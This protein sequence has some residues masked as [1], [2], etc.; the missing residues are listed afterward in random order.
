M[1]FSDPRRFIAWL[2]ILLSGVVSASAAQQREFTLAEPFGLSWGPDRVNVPVEFP[3]GEVAAD[4]VALQDAAG[5]AVPVQLD[6]IELWP[7]GKSVKK[8]L[9]SFMVTLE[10]DQT[11]AW[12]LTADPRSILQEAGGEVRAEIRGGLIELSNAKTGVRL[13]GGKRSYPEPVAGE[14]FPAPIQG[15]RLP[16]G[17]WIGKGS[18]QTDLGCTGYSAR[19]THRGPVFVRAK[20]RYEFEGCKFYAA[21]VEL[22]AGQDLAV[23]SEEYNLSEGRRYPMTGV[24]GMRPDVQYAYVRPTF[25]S[26][27]KALMWDW[28]GQTMAKLPTP[29]AYCFSFHE[30][31]RPDS[32]DFKGN[33]QYGNLKPGDGGLTYNKDG[34]FAYLNAYLQWGDEETLYLGLWNAKEPAQQIAFV[35]LRPSQWLHPDIDPHPSNIL[36]QYVQTNCPTFERRT[37]GEAFLRAP[38]CLGK[39]VYGLGG[40]LRKLEKQVLPERGGPAVTPR[41]QWGSNLMLRYIRLG[42]VELDTVRNWQVRYDEPGK[43][44]RMYVPEGD[45]ARYESRRTRRPLAEAQAALAARKE[46][47]EADRKA[48][49]DAIQKLRGTVHHFA[50]VAYGHMDYGINLGLIANAAED[51]LASPACTPRQAEDIRRWM[52]A[53]VYQALNPNFVPPRTAGFAW[54]SANMMAQVQCRV[55]YLASLL[56]NHPMAKRWREELAHVVTLYAEDQINEAGATLECPHYGSMAIIM[57]AH[58]LAALGN[59]TG[60]DLSRAERRLR[61]A[62]RSRLSTMLPWDLR[63][64]LRSAGSEGDSYYMGDET[65]APLAGFFQTRDPQLARQ[66]AWGLKESG[67]MLGGHADASFK[68]VDPGLEP[69]AP[70]LGS[71]HFPGFG[72]VLRNG[73]P[74]RDEACV[75]VYAG[76]FSWGHG[77]NDRGAWLLYAKG[78]PLMADFAGMY[79]PSMREQWMHPGGLTFNHDETVRPAGDD[80]KDDWWRGSANAGYRQLKTAPFTVVEMKENPEARDDL[81]TFGRVT[82][83]RAA[84]QADYAVMQR[85]VG[86]LHRVAFTLKEPHGQDGFDDSPHAEVK[87]KQPFLWT[88]QFAFVKD[89]DPMG[90]NYLVIRDDLAGNSELDPS[91]NLWALADRIT[92]QGQ[93]AIY[94]GQHGVDLHCYVAEP[95]RF[96]P[97]TRVVGHSAGFAFAK[98]YR[99]TF[100]KPF[101]EDQIQLRIPQ[102]SR[103]GGFF[104]AIV[105][106]KQGEPTPQFATLAG[107][108][109][110]RVKF[111]DRTDTI[112]MRKQPDDLDIDGLRVRG[113]AVLVTQ[114]GGKRVV[115]DLSL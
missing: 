102:A 61:A 40:V 28:W 9:A 74:R 16:N 73:F 79:T 43:Y 78:V 20:L 114:Q 8:A 4:G 36:K 45:R 63:G 2:L 65:F 83:F 100:G 91:L 25:A 106:V 77:H 12:R 112:V 82:A 95:A 101:R 27:D 108:R 89:A 71:A 51:A 96:T 13:A 37:S 32:A 55:C 64:D 50:Q 62:A 5:Q 80:P 93:V 69:L 103:G 19:I 47:A 98:H 57:P 35:A 88:R 21:T 14:Q 15:V 10:P 44:P 72:F 111:P 90:H 84:P 99:E 22:N 29:N 6:R 68:M 86:Y 17:M 54:G 81:G 46:P 33:S 34:R 66:L 75:L 7:D 107:G 26:P 92:V 38:V 109:A 23:V 18:W 53:I 85:Q 87:L 39:R 48:V 1:T 11:A 113:T 110:I 70:T 56:P 3:A 59:G 49:A 60:L 58:A 105:P 115:T 30:G 31:L 94:A 42:S 67:N 104:A 76:A 41:E 97:H 52:A 24:D